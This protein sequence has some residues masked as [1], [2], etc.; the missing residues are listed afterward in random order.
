M[1]NLRFMVKDC[2]LHDSANVNSGET[3]R[4][5]IEERIYYFFTRARVPIIYKYKNACFLYVEDRQTRKNM[6]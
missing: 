5:S 4:F 6:S 2:R 1:H 3:L